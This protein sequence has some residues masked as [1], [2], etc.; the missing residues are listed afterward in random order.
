MRTDELIDRLAGHLAPVSRGAAGRIL[1]AGVGGG[2]AVSFVL[3]AAWLGIR[4]DLAQAVSTGAYW[5]KFLYT[6]GFAAAGLGSVSRLARPGGR[7]NWAV[8][9]LPAALVAALAAAQWISAPPFQHHH[10]LM[11]ASHLVCPWRIVALSLP[12]FAGTVWSLRRLAPTRL[13]LTGAAA[14]LFAGAAGAWIYAFHCDESSA[15]FV[16][17]WYTLGIA[18]AGVLGALLGRRLLRW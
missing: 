17:V 14:G 11:G 9:L 4:P 5:M 18:L 7:P 10:L 8:E 12:V 6:L 13:L 3:M 16:A 2:S 15:V 1:A